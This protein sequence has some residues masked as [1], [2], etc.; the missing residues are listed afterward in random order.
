MRR[1][2][3]I[4]ADNGQRLN[5]PPIATTSH[6]QVCDVDEM[7]EITGC[8]APEGEPKRGNT[9]ANGKAIRSSSQCVAAVEYLGRIGKARTDVRA[10]LYRCRQTPN[11]SQTSWIPK[12]AVPH[13]TVTSFGP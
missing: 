12:E 2:Y 4:E 3:L 1:Q 10:R 6:V 13:I 7:F 8:E 5:G 11:Q 9:G